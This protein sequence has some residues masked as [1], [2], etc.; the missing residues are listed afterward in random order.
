VRGVVKDAVDNDE[1]EEEEEDQDDGS[2]VHDD[3]DVFARAARRGAD[4]AFFENRDSCVCLV[5][6][7]VCVGPSR[8]KTMMD[9]LDNGVAKSKGADPRFLTSRACVIGMQQR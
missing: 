2:V 9:K 7:C 6:L 5:C 4:W 8:S 3:D 1:E